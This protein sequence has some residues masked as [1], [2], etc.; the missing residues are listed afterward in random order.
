MLGSLKLSCTRAA[1]DS[2]WFKNGLE[3]GGQKRLSLVGGS[4]VEE[5]SKGDIAW[6]RNL[7]GLGDGPWKREV[8]E[9]SDQPAVRGVLHL[10]TDLAQLSSLPSSPT[11]KSI[12]S[13]SHF[14]FF[15][16]HL[17]PFSEAAE[18]PLFPPTAS[19]SRRRRIE[20][21]PSSRGRPSTHLPRHWAHGK[22]VGTRGR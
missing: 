8:S 3:I 10:H 12:I 5:R 6:T 2:S 16:L 19:V 21:I 11:Q 17:S 20:L 4:E 18:T 1:M 22:T 7:A 13:A 9:D 14:D 15:P